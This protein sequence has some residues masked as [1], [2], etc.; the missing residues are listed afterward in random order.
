MLRS[1]RRRACRLGGRSR[2]EMGGR[3]GAFAFLVSGGAPVRRSSRIATRG[4]HGETAGAC[5]TRERFLR[6][7]LASK[8]AMMSV[9]KDRS[10]RPAPAT[11]ACF[12]HFFAYVCYEIGAK[13]H[14][15][16]ENCGCGL[17]HW[18]CVD[19][20][21][22]A[23]RLPDVVVFCCRPERLRCLRHKVLTSRPA[24]LRV[25]GYPGGRQGTVV[26]GTGQM[27]SFQSRIAGLR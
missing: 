10:P 4:Q 9:A 2:G 20:G 18:R 27:L 11:G 1:C 19:S 14:A 17:G 21:E 22:R 23:C 15:I 6:F 8:Q 7:R 25:F 3:V 12:R 16:L 5:A 24:S 13:C 26:A